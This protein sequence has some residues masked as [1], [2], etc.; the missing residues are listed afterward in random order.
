MTTILLWHRSFV[1]DLR[2][3]PSQ[4]LNSSYSMSEHNTM[5]LYIKGWRSN[6]GGEFTSKAFRN[7]LKDNGIHIH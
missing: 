1:S 3:R 7:Y 2:I 4:L 6:A 5:L